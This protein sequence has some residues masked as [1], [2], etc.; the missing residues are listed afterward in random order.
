MIILNIKYKLKI[1]RKKF[2]KIKWLLFTCARHVIR[3]LFDG[4]PCKEK[5]FRLSYFDGQ[6][7]YHI[8]IFL[9]NKKVDIWHNN[10]FM[11]KCKANLIG[12]HSMFDLVELLI[13]PQ[14]VEDK[15]YWLTLVKD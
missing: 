10:T 1:K 3:S 8:L 5:S 6:V 14:L 13:C 11:P 12:G 7:N 2:I 15:S 4:A 9:Y